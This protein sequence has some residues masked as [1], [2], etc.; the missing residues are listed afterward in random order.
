MWQ[1]QHLHDASLTT[2]LMYLGMLSSISWHTIFTTL[3]GRQHAM[4]CPVLCCAACRCASM[5]STF[6]TCAVALPHF[7][8]SHPTVLQLAC[9]AK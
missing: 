9:D 4:C 5:V 1:R 8:G 6:R 3:A 2:I 7:L